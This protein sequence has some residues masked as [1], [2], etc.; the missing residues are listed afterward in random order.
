MENLFTYYIQVIFLS[1]I[2]INHL[3]EIYL[4]RRQLNVLQN[5]RGKVPEEFTK[6]LTLADH[7]KAIAYASAKLNYSQAHLLWD[8]ILLFYW[9]PF[10]G[11][12]KLFLAIP[13]WGIHRDVIFLLSFGL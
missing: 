10:R 4:S 6:A 13:N 1:I 8:A 2:V 9:F 7:Q 3:M 5:N 12:E 11:A